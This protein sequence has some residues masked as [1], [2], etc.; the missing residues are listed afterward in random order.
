MILNLTI[1]VESNKLLQCG[2]VYDGLTEGRVDM[3]VQT[4]TTS[5][6][7]NWVGFGDDVLFYE[8]AVVS[9]KVRLPLPSSS[10]DINSNSN[11]DII[12]GFLFTS[13]F[14]Y[15]IFIFIILLKIV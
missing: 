8:W 6:A 11:S 5:I 7:A 4:S 14:L 9:D 3:K 15:F 1:S 13:F 12:D 2:K 10:S